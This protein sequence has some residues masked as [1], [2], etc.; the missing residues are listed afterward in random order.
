MSLLRT[1]Q[2]LRA[3]G[4]VEVRDGLV[5]VRRRE[6]L[7]LLLHHSRYVFEHVV[8]NKRI[9]DLCDEEAGTCISVVP[10]D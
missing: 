2:E 7:R 6:V 9:Y 3:R 1:V 4:L 5:Y 8:F 10:A